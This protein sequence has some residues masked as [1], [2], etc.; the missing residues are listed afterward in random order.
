MVVEPCLNVS[1]RPAWRRADGIGAV[2][3]TALMAGV[4]VNMHY[5]YYPTLSSLFGQ[6]EANLVSETGLDK[7]RG[8]GSPHR[9]A[10]RQRRDGCR[11]GSPPPC[12]T[13]TPGAAWKDALP[14]T[15]WRVG[16]GPVPAS[17]V[18][19]CQPPLA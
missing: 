3:L 11:Y 7:L 5:D 14:W 15:A 10:S 6:N 8:R 1:R 9:Q 2:V 16:A 18:A 4:L 13:S 19:T 12:P 17:T